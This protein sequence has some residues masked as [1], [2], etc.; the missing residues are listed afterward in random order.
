MMCKCSKKVTVLMCLSLNSRLFVHRCSRNCPEICPFTSALRNPICC[1]LFTF[2][3]HSPL[4]RFPRNPSQR[5]QCR[6]PTSG[7]ST[8]SRTY[9]R[10]RR[11]GAW[12]ARLASSPPSPWFRRPAT[13]PLVAPRLSKRKKVGLPALN[14]HVNTHL[15]F[16]IF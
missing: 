7:P 16:N 8:S 14:P 4:S 12:A 1:F 15:F 6:D 9:S 10:R 5:G 3:F 2:C 11:S 13:S